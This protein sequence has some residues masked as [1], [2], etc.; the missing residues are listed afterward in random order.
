VPIALFSAF[1][2]IAA[3]A[4]LGR[5]APATVAAPAVARQFTFGAQL[6]QQPVWSPDGQLIA[7]A[8]ASG[9][10]SDIWVQHA[11]DSDPVRITSSPA[12]DWQPSW[13]PDG[14]WLAFRSERDGGGIWVV[15]KDGEQEHLLIRRGAS[16]QWS[17]DGKWI[18]FSSGDGR[19]S[20]AWPH[21]VSSAG[22]PDWPVLEDVL[23]DSANKYAAWHPDGRVSVWFRDDK[24]SWKFITA[25]ATGGPIVESSISSD[26]ERGLTNAGI[27]LR[28][29]DYPFSRLER[30]VW[31]PSGRSLYF[32]AITEGAR[33]IWRISIDRHTLAW[34]RGPDPVTTGVG[35]HAQIALSADGDKLAFTAQAAR[36]RVWAIP[37][38]GSGRQSGTGTPLTPGRDE[39]VYTKATPDGRVLVYRSVQGSRNE[40]KILDAASPEHRTLITGIDRN[41]L[42][43]S[44]DG[45]RVV[46]TRF[47][48]K[49]PNYRNHSKLITLPL[50]GGDERLLFD[51][52]RLRFAPLDWSVDGALLL[53]RCIA[54]DTGASSICTLPAQTDRIPEQALR[55]IT[56][57]KAAGDELRAATISPDR[58]WIAFTEVK[59]SRSA[60]SIVYVMPAQGGAWTAIAGGDV[61]NDRARW[62]P[63]GAT[64]YFLSNRTGSLNVWGQSFDA[65]TGRPVRDAFPVTS[66]SDPQLSIPHGVESGF[67]V[68][69]THLFLPLT[70]LSA[71]IWILPG[72]GQ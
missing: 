72:L 25:P 39:E 18:L 45:R 69:S 53:G 6:Q 43:L 68:T 22:G 50:A 1:G 16:P 10:N 27:G 48:E 52:A 2:V 17:P 70:E 40:F 38:D 24:G 30:F 47:G 13:S 12:H 54:L 5:F 23:A 21:V 49:G 20:T 9:G 67:A 41:G 59:R 66:F 55:I 14:G 34:K 4:G 32:E 8:S 19:S 71:N 57:P 42:Q 28:G 60:S 26:V 35:R 29:L 62:A 51:S 46:Y 31:A 61:Y 36:T 65:T 63:D 37:L 64:L 44:P 58:R 3:F 33:S 56:T 15:R 7:Y 11:A